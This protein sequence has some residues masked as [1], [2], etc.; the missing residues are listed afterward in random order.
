MRTIF[1]CLLTALMISCKPS[2]QKI[3]EPVI[4]VPDTVYVEVPVINEERIKELESDVQFWRHKVDSLNTT[5]S[6][7]D[8]INARRM[9]KVKYYISICEK[10]PSNKKFF[11]G[12]IKRT[13]FEE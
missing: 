6:Y 2:A 12:W 13:V 9:E 8:Y 7:E 11:Y 3:V 10:K 1:L 5:I 4:Q